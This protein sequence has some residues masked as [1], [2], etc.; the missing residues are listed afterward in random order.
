MVGDLVDFGKDMIQ[1]ISDNLCRP[2]GRNTDP[3]SGTGANTTVPMSPFIFGAISQ[4]S[5]CI[6]CDLV[7]FYQTIYHPLKAP[8]I[9]LDPDVRLLGNSGK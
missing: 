1:Q 6:A 5:L 3:V 2:G 7:R 9:Q 4:N 8:N